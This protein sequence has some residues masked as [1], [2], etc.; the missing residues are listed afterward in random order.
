M[1]GRWRALGVDVE[2]V[3]REPR[4]LPTATALVR[5]QLAELDAVASRFRDSELTRLRP[6][7]QTVSPLL[8]EL[9]R[10][11]LDAA[12]A[13]DGLVDPTVGA[14]VVAAGYDRTFVDLPADGPAVG[15][16]ETG[17]WREV[18]LDGDVLHLPAISLDLGAT[19]KAWAAD[20]AATSVAERTGSE[21]VVS[22]GG[23]VAAVGSWPVRVG[24]PGGPSEVV[25][26]VG[27][28]ATSSTGRRRWRRGGVEQHHL[29]DPRTGRPAAEHWRTVAV[30]ARTCVEANTASTAAV[31][32]GAAGTGWLGDLPARLVRRDGLVVRTGGWGVGAAA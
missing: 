26:V 22:L 2:L 12:E 19:A 16:G 31:V 24:D 15:P 10:A 5:Q 8:A 13:T 27:G 23:D 32:L 11:A 28:L 20:R 17:R 1:R 7:R 4:T 30:A 14:A 21:V 18:H 29:V 9:L 25:E 3:V 6:G